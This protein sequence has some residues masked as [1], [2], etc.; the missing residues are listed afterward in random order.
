MYAEALAWASGT[1]D[2]DTVL[3]QLYMLVKRELALLDWPTTNQQDP[4]GYAIFEMVS[5]YGN[6]SFNPYDIWRE[7]NESGNGASS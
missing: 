3:S 7:L 6:P 5:K 4:Y 2:R 1:S